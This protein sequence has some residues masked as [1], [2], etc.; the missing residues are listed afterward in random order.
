MAQSEHDVLLHELTALRRSEAVLRDFLETSTI[1][2]HWLGADGAILWANQA[3]LDLLGYTREEYVGRNIAEFHVDQSVINDMLVRVSRGE[4]LRD[5]PAPLRHRDGS[6]RHVLINSSVLFEDGKFIHTRCFTRD[7]TA[8]REREER[9]RFAQ[10]AARIGIFDWNI[11]TGLNTWTKELEA[12]YGLP[13]GGFA[14]TQ[15]A[16]E[17]LVHPDDR[18]RAV[19]RV[20][21]SLETGEPVEEEWRVVWPDGSVHWLAGRW[22]VFKSKFGNPVRLMGVNIDVTDRK[23]MEEALRRSEERLRLA[24]K[25]TNDAIWDIDLKA[26]TVSWNDTYSTL[27][28]RPESADSWQF[29]IDRIHPEDRPRTVDEFQT[30]IACGAS[31]WTSQYRFRRV[32]GKWAYIYDRAYI[33]RDESGKAWRVI[34]AMQDLTEQKHAEATL[35]ASEERFRRVFEEGPLGV[36]LLG[37]NHRFLRVNNALCQMLGYSEAEL[38]RKTCG[39]ITHP[40]DVEADAELEERLFRCEIPSYHLQKRYV[41]KNGEVI[42]VNL[43]KSLILDEKGEPLDGLSMVEDIT[44]IKRTQEE[45]LLRQKLESLG[46]LAGGIAHDFNNLLGAVQAQAELALAE[47]QAGSSCKE[48]LR[49]IGEVAMRGSEIVRQLMIYA[50]REIA[51]VGLV[52]L[53]KTVDEM[54]SLLKVSV[55]KHA[56]IKTDLGPDL[57]AIRASA[58]QIRQIVMNLVTNASDAIGDRD[59][60]IHVI[61]R[62]VT[63]EESATIPE[64]APEID[65]VSLEVSDTGSGMSSET[66]ARLFDPFFTTKSAG[67]GLGLA[68]VSGIVRSLG[69][70]IHLQSELG[71]GTTFQILLPS[72]VGA[73][74]SS[75]ISIEELA[76]PWQQAT[77]LVVEDE[78]VLREAVAKMLRNNGFEVFE[79]ADGSFAIDLLRANPG[80]IDVILLDMTTPGAS[81]REVVTEAVKVRPDTRVVLTSAYG[82]ET[83][84]SEMNLPQIKSFIRK[85]FQLANV[86]RTLRHSLAS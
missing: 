23:Q 82:Q 44:E 40:D 61:T 67:R 14:G 73:A 17:A 63:L 18:Q 65:Y 80:K 15:A 55:T 42:W 1:G 85:P 52:D 64:S 41:K 68:V 43:T 62:R 81:C 10:H 76:D 2:L 12:M 39:D 60:V 50:G 38:V 78:E 75:I 48:E 37:K 79:A 30:A 49:A 21:E 36:A 47:L 46:T 70:T 7:V 71:K 57:P 9:L 72:T 74:G 86:V 25:A 5:Y 27:Y 19:A 83:L 4:T 66:Q 54:H 77:V 28:G 22:Q 59:G 45:A 24:I 3:E 35:R 20:T 13:P 32:D 11:E 56:L 29:W 69:G 16:W 51:A 6:T 84:T 31:S 58:A 33:A 26:G 8:L 53:S 34:G